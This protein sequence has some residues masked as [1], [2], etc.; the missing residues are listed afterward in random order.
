EGP[1]RAC[2]HRD[3]AG[4]AG[5]GLSQLGAGAAGRQR[6]RRGAGANGRGGGAVG[7]PDHLRLCPCPVPLVAG[8]DRGR[9]DRG[10]AGG[11]GLVR[12]RLSRRR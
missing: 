7:H 11:G 1:D 3:G 4:V 8:P 5:H 9:P 2:A 10:P 12:D 6:P